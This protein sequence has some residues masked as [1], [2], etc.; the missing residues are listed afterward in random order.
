MQNTHQPADATGQQHQPAQPSA[1]SLT[2]AIPR[3]PARLPEDVTALAT[4]RD[5]GIRDANN[6]NAVTKTYHTLKDLISAK[7][8]KD[9]IGGAD[10]LMNNAAHQHQLQQQQQQLQQQITKTGDEDFRSPYSAL[11]VHMRQMQGLNQS[12]P[13]IWNGTASPPGS[14]QEQQQLGR[15]TIQPGSVGGPI[16]AQR[17]YAASD[18][19]RGVQQRAISQPQ[20]NMPSFERRDQQSLQSQGDRCGSLANIDVTDSD[21]GGFATRVLRRPHTVYQTP[22]Q[23]LTSQQQ[24]ISQR[25]SPQSF[26]HVNGNSYN[27]QQQYVSSSQYQHSHLNPAMYN[28]SYHQQQQQQMQQ[29][30]LNSQQQ[31]SAVVHQSLYSTQPHLDVA[32]QLQQ[33]SAS[34][35]IQSRQDAL[36]ASFQKQMSD[37]QQQAQQVRPFGQDYQLQTPTAKMLAQRSDII[38]HQTQGMQSNSQPSESANNKPMPGS[39]GSS[40]YDKSGNHSSNVDSGRGSAAYSSGRKMALDADSLDS[41]RA[42]AINNKSDDSEWVDIVDSE[43][44]H[45]LEPN[46]QNLSIR[47]ESTVS[48]S[49][50]SMSPPLP[51]L[52]PGGSSY[53]PIKVF[54]LNYWPPI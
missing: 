23:H 8:K 51:P 31:Q 13:N 53:K 50:S 32:N 43:L 1:S 3:T 29:E 34:Q 49:V 48:G 40:D 42:T 28:A 5:T 44:R 26:Q 11:P 14:I 24:Q 10:E 22:P 46:M 36:R 35:I 19:P 41:P 20:L 16:I 18:L 7:F 25:Q 54:W 52:S 6:K 17:S 38:R 30:L 21:E 47:P 45:I 33:D 37:I 27:G 4:D 2:G 12:Q 15:Q 9:S 39:A